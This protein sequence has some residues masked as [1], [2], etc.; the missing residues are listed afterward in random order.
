M[1][2]RKV[3]FLCTSNS[4][5]SQMAEAI[6]NTRMGDRWE[7]VSAGTH[8]SGH[9]HPKALAALE[10]INIT[11]RGVSKCVDEFRDVNFDLVITVCNSAAEACPAWL[12]KG[13]RVHHG[14]PDPA[15]A[16]NIE[17]F[18]K[19]RYDIEREIIPLLKKFTT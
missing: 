4:C 13:A 18:R 6:V 16:D 2:K 19:V 9:I 5:R 12:G 11:H 1:S 14:F 17:V 15:E 8:P 3:L 7:A 10:E